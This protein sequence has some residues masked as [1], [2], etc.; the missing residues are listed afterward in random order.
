ML[1]TALLCFPYMTKA[2]KNQD[3]FYLY[4]G[5]YT[6]SE[7]EG[8]VVYRFDALQGALHYMSTTQGVKNPSYLAIDARRNHLLAVNEIEVYKGQKTGAVS[9]F[10][11]N[12][13]NGS[14]SL[15]NQ[16]ASG[17]ASPCY[18]SI[19]KGGRYAYVANY[20]GGNVAML[21]VL[22]DGTIEPFSDLQLHR[23]SGTVAG[24]QDKPH[25]HA[26]MIAPNNQM[27]VVVDLG[28][29]KVITYD[30]D[31]KGGKLVQ[32]NEFN[33]QD[34]SGPRHLA[35]HPKGKFVYIISELSS[36]ISACT[37]DAK[38]GQI[39]E[40][41][42]VSTLPV[43]YEGNNSC[44]DI[45]ISPDGRHLYGSNRGHNSIAIFDIDQDTGSI[46]ATGHRSVNGKTPRNFVIDP[47]GKFMLV[48]NQDSNNIVV[49]KIDKESGMLKSNGVEVAVSK[50]VCLKLMV[51]K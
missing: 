37:W 41:M 16:E 31:A 29:D 9:S 33:M 17:G 43:D 18:I 4:V 11:I 7:E 10:N 30:I 28:I 1:L 39:S 24:R 19:D 23:G 42:K 27:V 12:P 45:H 26:S 13:A 2:Q 35:F 25:A 49:F 44:A 40:L 47:T 51:S 22:P 3:Q 32:M 14:L 5:V 36:T 20:G 38:S 8:I 46:T 50:P 6:Q 48:A 34:G 15:I 21:P